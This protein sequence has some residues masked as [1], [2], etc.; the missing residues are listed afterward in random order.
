VNQVRPVAGDSGF[1]L[2]ETLVALGILL[3]VSTIV[4]T[5]LIR[6]TEAQGTIWN[7]SEMHSGVR[8]ATELLQQEVGQ[9]G[10]ITLPAAVTM[11]TAVAAP[12]AAT[13]TLSSVTGMFVGE[14]LTFDSGTNQETAA[15]TAI[16]A[17]NNQIT[18]A[19]SD[20]HP[21]N[22]PVTV[23]GGFA[24]GIVPTNVA[25]GSNASRLKLFGDINGDGNMVYVEYWCDTA[26][27][28][29][30][31]NMMPFTAAAKTPF[32]A[33]Q[34]LLSNVQP[35]PGG[36]PCFTYQQVTIPPFT[37]VTDVAITL[38]V[39]TQ[40]IDPVTKQFQRETKA[41]LNV[42]PRNVLNAEQLAGIGAGYRVQ[43]TPA[44]VTNLLK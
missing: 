17:G 25:N 44:T 8:S 36:A 40:Q 43:P 23:L 16:N 5:G 7:R 33:T 12:G 11:Q 35:N 13:V 2:L 6:M 26:S 39:R 38:T 4:S 14:Q 19:F 28:N 37:F 24:N 3:L 41:L 18:A 30:Y 42:S 10:L 21:A 34:V 15:V 20:A 29:L 22:V 1:S 9:A 32:T 31:R 27:G